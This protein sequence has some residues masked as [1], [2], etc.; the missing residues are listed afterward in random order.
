MLSSYRKRS[1]FEHEGS[2]W[3]RFFSLPFIF[4][5]YVS[6]IS[7]PSHLFSF[8]P[9]EKRRKRKATSAQ[10]SDTH[11]HSSRQFSAKRFHSARGN[12]CNG[13]M[14]GI[15]NGT[16]DILG[17]AAVTQLNLGNPEENYG[18]SE[19]VVDYVPE[20]RQKPS[21][22]SLKVKN[23]SSPLLSV[24]PAA[25]PPL[26]T[27]THRPPSTLLAKSSKWSQ[28]L[29]RTQVCVYMRLYV[30]VRCDCVRCMC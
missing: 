26:Q 7:S 18:S 17:D 20:R 25:A 2:L 10:K 24:P 29:V 14:K 12:D 13:G 27:Q 21:S 8:S 15:K 6:F 30:Y 16:R 1:V 3:A 11:R 22:I 4:S 9:Q 23:S 28:F 5:T 19:I